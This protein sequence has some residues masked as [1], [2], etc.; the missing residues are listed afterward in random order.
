MAPAGFRVSG[1]RDR[2]VGG[3]ACR[4]AIEMKPVWN[5]ERL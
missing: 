3:I 5:A 1:A 2:P 4:V